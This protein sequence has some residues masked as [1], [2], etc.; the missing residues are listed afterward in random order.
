MFN[1]RKDGE[2]PL[3][4]MKIEQEIIKRD[5]NFLETLDFDEKINR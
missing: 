3:S 5:I 4:N 2:D 1:W